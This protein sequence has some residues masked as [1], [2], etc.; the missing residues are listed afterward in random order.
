MMHL[1][2]S[3]KTLLYLVGSR[4]KIHSIKLENKNLF[5][6][7]HALVS[8]MTYTFEFLNSREKMLKDEE[9]NKKH[10]KG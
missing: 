2:K 10:K 5:H 6:E 1:T 4:D 3:W 9:E 7:R 8:S